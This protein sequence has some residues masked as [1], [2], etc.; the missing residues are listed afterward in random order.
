VLKR[1]NVPY[2]VCFNLKKRAG[3]KNLRES[4]ETEL[5]SHPETCEYLDVPMIFM[6]PYNLARVQNRFSDIFYRIHETIKK[7]HFYICV[8]RKFYHL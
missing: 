1:Y 3:K 7:I 2:G 8:C 5:K 6:F 4:E